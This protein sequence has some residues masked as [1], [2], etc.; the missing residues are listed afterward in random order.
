MASRKQ[1]SN[2]GRMAMC[3]VN[4]LYILPGAS[5]EARRAF[6]RVQVARCYVPGV[7]AHQC[8]CAPT[9]C[10]AHKRGRY[11][12]VF[13]RPFESHNPLFNRSLVRKA[14]ML[15]PNPP[16]QYQNKDIRHNTKPKHNQKTG[17]APLVLEGSLGIQSTWPPA[18]KLPDME[19]LFRDAPI[20]VLGKVLVLPI[21]QCS[22]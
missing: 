8:S 14:L 5:C 22:Q 19:N 13:P 7:V 10:A 18:K 16:K 17:L 15:Y 2:D 9:L 4:M 6:G 21:K 3:E 1:S 12:E 11:S 20:V